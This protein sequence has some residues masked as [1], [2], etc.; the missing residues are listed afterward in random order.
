MLAA[1]TS[2]QELKYRNQKAAVWGHFLFS[3]LAIQEPGERRGALLSCMLGI[4]LG[5]SAEIP[6]FD[7]GKLEEGS[8]AE[9]GAG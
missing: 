4:S 1:T 9:R 3:L 2:F 7:F 8:L 6:Y 5:A